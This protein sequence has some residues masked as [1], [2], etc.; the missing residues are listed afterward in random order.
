MRKRISRI[1]LAFL[2]ILVAGAYSLSSAQMAGYCQTPP[3]LNL[4]AQPNILLVVD[5]SGSMSWAA[6][7]YGDRDADNNDVLDRYNNNVAYEGYFRPDRYYRLD[8]SG[9]YEETVPPACCLQKTCTT[10]CNFTSGNYLNYERME[11]IDLIR[12]AMTGGTPS[13]CT[14]SQ[15][16]NNPYC[17]PELWTQSGNTASGK[18][19]TVCNNSLDVNGDGVA[20]G[21]CILRLNNGN[22]VKVPWSRMND[23]LVF[24]F[25]D[26]PTMPRMGAMFFSGSGVGANKVYIGDFTAPSSKNDNFPYMNLITH[27]N[28]Y[29]PNGSTPT[30]PALWDAFHYFSQTRA[31]YGGFLVQSGSADRWKNPMY[32]CDSSG[33]QCTYVPC[34]NNFVLLMSDGQWNMGG[35]PP[36]TSTCSISSGFEMHSAD[37]VVPAYKMHMGFTNAATGVPANVASVYTI[38]LFLG[39]SGELAMKNTA[40]YGSFANAAQNWP[41]N[42]TGYPQ[43]TCTAADCGSSGRGSPCTSLPPP[44]AD[45]D[46]DANG[47]PD[48][49]F[50]ADNA[51][52]V[53]ET[54]MGTIMDMLKTVSS[55]TAAS[56]LA[57][58]EGSGANVMQGAFYPLRVFDQGVCLETQTKVCLKD[59]DCPLGETCEKEIAW[60]GSL[61]NLWYYLDPRLAQST[62]RE[63]TLQN[64][65]LVLTEDDIVNLEF[66]ASSQKTVARL[67]KSDSAGNPAG[68]D[69]GRTSSD[70]TLPAGTV[71]LDEL[72]NLWDAGALLH[73]RNLSGDP[74]KIYT[75]TNGTLTDFASLNTASA[76]IRGY[77]QAADQAEAD[78]IIAYTLGRDQTVY[79]SRKITYKGLINEWRLGDIINSTPKVV[80]WLPLNN[81]HRDY[82]DSTYASFL[83]SDKYKYRGRIEKGIS[84]GR[85]L[86]FA[87]ANDG[88]LHTFTLGAFELVNDSAA[89]TTKARIS[90]ANRGREEWAFIPKNALPYLKYIADPNYC[91]L[92]TVDLP[93]VIIDASIGDPGIGDISGSDRD[94]NSWRTILI[95]GMRLG[96]ACRDASATCTN[97]VKT[98]ASAIGFSSYFALDITDNLRDPSKEPKLLWEFS[99]PGLGFSNTGPAIVRINSRVNSNGT[100]VADSKKNGKWF[101]VFA[102]GPTGPIDATTHQFRAYS[103]QPLKLFVLDLKT[104]SQLA[105]IPTGLDYAFGGSLSNA[106]MDYDLDYQDDAVYFGYTRSEDNN[107]GAG[108]RWRNGGVIRLSTNTGDLSPD[109]AKWIVSHVMQ[110][111]GSVTSAVGHTAFYPSKSKSPTKGYLFFGTGRYFFKD[112]AGSDDLSSQR[113]IFGL[114]EPCVTGRGFDSACTTSV[115]LSDINNVTTDVD[116]TK[117][118]I[119]TSKGWY[120]KLESPSNTQLSGAG[121]SNVTTT[122]ER[123][124]TDPLV[125]PSGVVLFT[126]FMPTDDA[127]SSGGSTFL[128]ALRYDTGSS[129]AS[130]LKGKALLQVS[131]GEVKEIDLQKAFTTKFAKATYDD[132]S[133]VVEKYGRRTGA[134]RGTPPSGQGLVLLIPPRP[135]DS[136]MHIRK[137]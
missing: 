127:C 137:K 13:T 76:T 79:R 17:D 56:M 47:V 20:D 130:Y 108:T 27:V 32:T 97:C 54:I 124:I 34:A 18:V 65:T 63:D 43:G 90:G 40:L 132:G 21:G 106:S 48:T 45:W 111:A 28:S 73:A 93:P 70:L 44:S 49:F 25:K 109:P 60:T 67:S 22:R 113:M 4:V 33:L 41:G 112:P 71:N 6:Y 92:Y 55:G 1:F 50:K 131:T 19:G 114:R 98:P 38:G 122:A 119:D 136:F 72:R 77:L 12:W 2:T 36:A 61:Q 94:V 118:G 133:R 30:G 57:S 62:I 101:V 3:T 88:M 11:R 99:D 121:E 135:M 84:Y 96:G 10:G 87:G 42:L 125:T 46:R 68:A 110:N 26:L 31:E 83:S 91:H 104:G 74:R 51:L 7:S 64:N 116:L 82:H 89:W 15:T 9:V 35:G 128:W 107:P 24:R 66:D 123:V 29:A 78:R 120:I 81:Y 117:G 129:G 37:P 16:F 102:S 75:H 8:G 126:T 52:E 23:G 39:G 59:S 58:N 80:S 95:G 85:G 69:T 14:G 100:T 105:A 103:D 134:I 115:A 86:V 5:V 53:R